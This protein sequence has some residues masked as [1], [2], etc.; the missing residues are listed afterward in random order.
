MLYLYN[1]ERNPIHFTRDTIE[2][3]FSSYAEGFYASIIA[4]FSTSV[5]NTGVP[6]LAAKCLI[7]QATGA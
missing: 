7:S 4:T 3:Q 2:V 1:L 5:I 6:Q